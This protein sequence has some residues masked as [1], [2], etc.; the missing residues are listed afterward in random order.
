M[1]VGKWNFHCIWESE[2]LVVKLSTNH[3]EGLFGT[4]MQNGTWLHV[5]DFTIFSPGVSSSAP[6][7]CKNY[8]RSSFLEA[9]ALVCGTSVNEQVKQ[10][11]QQIHEFK[12]YPSCGQ[13]EGSSLRN[14]SKPGSLVYPFG[15]LASLLCVSR[16]LHCLALQG[17]G[18]LLL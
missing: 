16:Y 4:K 5:L 9:D 2:E 10:S 17:G 8:K 13:A 18:S 15:L 1:D 14:K 6:Y 7:T 11:G 3:L 12:V